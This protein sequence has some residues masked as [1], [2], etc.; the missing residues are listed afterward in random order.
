MVIS[1]NINVC[2]LENAHTHVIY[3]RKLS[4]CMV[5]SNNINVCILENAHTH[6]IY[7]RK[8]FLGVILLSSISAFILMQEDKSELVVYVKVPFYF[9][10]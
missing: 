7:V 8:L 1:N 6:V 3:V 5:I 2:I 4:V 10:H 9:R